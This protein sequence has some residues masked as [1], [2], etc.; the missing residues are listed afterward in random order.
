MALSLIDKSWYERPED[1]P[2]HESAG[3]VIVREDGE[4][5]WVALIRE[6]DYTTLVLPKGHVDPGESSEEAARREIEEESGLSDL[7]AICRLGTRERLSFD[8]SAWK[9]THY[10]LFLTDQV[11]GM[12]TDPKHPHPPEWH[13][14]DRLPE[15]MWPEQQ[16]LIETRRQEILKSLKERG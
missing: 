4:Q 2:E 6:Q 7:V 13:P 11:D 1:V 3:G 14:L 16:E 8:K 10:Y 15:L 5:V 12:P 9:R